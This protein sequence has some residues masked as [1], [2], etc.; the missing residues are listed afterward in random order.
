MYFDLRF[1]SNP[2]LRVASRALKFITSKQEANE[3]W[4]NLVNTTPA[5]LQD[6]T[7]L[8]IATNYGMP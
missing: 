8:Y 6:D 4:Y 3:P 1:E 2:V 7:L 5:L